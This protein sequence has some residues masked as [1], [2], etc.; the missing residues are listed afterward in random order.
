MLRSQQCKSKDYADMLN[1]YWYNR[2]IILDLFFIV[3]EKLLNSRVFKY[4]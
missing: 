2:I 3:K 4:R 1:N